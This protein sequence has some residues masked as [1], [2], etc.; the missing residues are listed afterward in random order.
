M[1]S[2]DKSQSL[3]QTAVDMCDRAVTNPRHRRSTG[4]YDHLDLTNV[5]FRKGDPRDP[6]NASKAKA[7][8]E[9]TRDLNAV[10]GPLLKLHKKLVVQNT[11]LEN[12]KKEVKR[13][14]AEVEYL[15]QLLEANNGSD[16][17]RHKKS[18]N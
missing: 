2:N 15:K 4:V 3:F 13:L 7:E 12:E 9:A 5:T 16:T 1:T 11:E 18:G 6:N 8:E 14:E 10:F 17:K